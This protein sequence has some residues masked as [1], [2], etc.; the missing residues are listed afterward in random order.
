VDS[1]GE[2]FERSPKNLVTPAFWPSFFADEKIACSTIAK[3]AATSAAA[4]PWGISRRD[5][6]VRRIFA[7]R[8]NV[9]RIS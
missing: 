5:H 1:V 7:A 3:E 8:D 9:E 6:S 2:N 4:L